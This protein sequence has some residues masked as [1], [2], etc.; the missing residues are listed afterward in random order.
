MLSDIKPY[1]SKVFIVDETFMGDLKERSQTEYAL[2][3]HPGIDTEILRL[4]LVPERIESVIRVIDPSAIH[5]G[6]IV[7]KPTYSNEFV[8]IGQVSEDVV[9]RKYGLFVQL[10]VLLGATKVKVDSVEVVKLES[11]NDMK[12]DLDASGNGLGVGVE[13]SGH[14]EKSSLSK[15][16]QESVTQLSVEADGGE[17]DL[18]AAEALMSRYGLHKDTL[19]NGMLIMRQTRSNKLRRHE[20]TLDSSR[21]MSRIFDHSLGVKL[22]VMSKLYKGKAEFEYT[23]K[24]IEDSKC[25][26]QL[27]VIVEF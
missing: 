23:R 8:P 22:E 13:A 6:N 20:L 21:D 14:T 7:V 18:E 16:F 5:S 17:P 15:N 11:G 2:F 26:T 1:T 10:C 19:F 9:L 3:A 4:P 25:A 27:S 12:A 24:S